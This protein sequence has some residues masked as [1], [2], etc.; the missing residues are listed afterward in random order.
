MYDLHMEPFAEVSVI[1]QDLVL[2]RPKLINNAKEILVCELLTVGHFENIVHF[3]ASYVAVM[4]LVNLLNY[5]HNIAQFVVFG[6]D[7]YELY[8]LYWS[9]VLVY[10]L[11]VMGGSTEVAHFIGWVVCAMS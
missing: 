2:E 3:V 10:F 11:P 5:Q 4:V 7:P 9:Q 8:L 6:K 1:N